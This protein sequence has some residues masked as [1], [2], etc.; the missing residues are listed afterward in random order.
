MQ[1]HLVRASHKRNTRKRVGRGN[2]SGSGTYSGRG[3]KGQNSR[4]GGGVRPG[5][6]GGQNPLIKGLPHLRGFNNIFRVENQIVNLDG[7]NRL[8]AEV[9]E[10]NPGVLAELGLIDNLNKPIKILGRG[11]ITRILKFNS[12]KVSESARIKIESLGGSVNEG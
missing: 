4:S 5:F 1:P 10:I 11:E 8:P 12:V 6:E 2:G 9:V 3:R 7:L